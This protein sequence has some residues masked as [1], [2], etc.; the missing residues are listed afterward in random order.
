MS[1]MGEMSY[2]LG[3]QVKEIEYGIFIHH[4]KY[5]RNLLERFGMQDSSAASTPMVTT[6]KLDKDTGASGNIT[7]Y[8]V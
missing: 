5:T 4:S 8:R 1:M 3:L 6:T 7:S 2:F